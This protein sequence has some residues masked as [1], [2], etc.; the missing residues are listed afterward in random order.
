MANLRKIK[1]DITF[2]VSEVIFDCYLFWDFHPDVKEQDVKDIVYEALNLRSSLY[3]R[4]NAAPKE[5]AK[6]H[7]RAISK[8]L[9]DGVENLFGRISTLSSGGEAVAEQAV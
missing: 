6:Q 1:K 7:Y 2:L 4:V 3:L 8:D 5:G 9:H